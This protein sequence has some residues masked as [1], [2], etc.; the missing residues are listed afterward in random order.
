MK[1]NDIERIIQELQNMLSGKDDPVMHCEL[2]SK[3]GC[4]HVGGYLCDMN[5][6]D[7]RQK[8]L[9]GTLKSVEDQ[10][11]VGTLEGAE[12]FS[13]KRNYPLRNK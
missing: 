13:K 1:T 5:T 6:C 8:F 7:I 3:E 2:Y 12:E 11:E 4:T 9:N 10:Y